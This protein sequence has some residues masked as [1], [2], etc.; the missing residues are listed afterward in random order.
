MPEASGLLTLSIVVPVYNGE[1]YL[2]DLVSQIAALKKRW[3]D[4]GVDLLVAEAIFVL[5]APTDQSR[6]V[7]EASRGTHPWLRLVDLS[8][9]FGQHS[10]TVAGILYS[11]GDWVAT[12]D[13]DLQHRP[14]HIETLLKRACTSEADVVYALPD[15]RVHGGGYRDR[16]SRLAKRV[17]ALVSGNRFVLSFNSFRLIRGD[18]ARA[19]SSIC[20]QYTYFD[21]ALTWFTQR[22]VTVRLAMSDERYIRGKISG[23]RL[24]TLLQHARR[25]ILTS[26]FRILRLTTFL[27]VTAF[28][29]CLLYG[30]WVLYSRFFAEHPIMVQGWTSLMLVILAFG[31]VSIFF[32]GLIAEFLHMSML[33]L[34]GKPTFFAVNRTTD[35]RL[36]TEIEKLDALCKS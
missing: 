27:S 13:E 16:F 29:S 24:S 15:G 7:L 31:G 11:S 14:H 26:D 33:Q 34:Q 32:L 9:N 30:S 22:I 1:S 23:Y 4:A 35:S 18:I 21:V 6:S 8:R 10:A 28:A 36:A 20:A 25:L 12:L 17:I 19:A 3:E 2:A 5:D